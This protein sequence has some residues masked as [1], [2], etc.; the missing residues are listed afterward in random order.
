MP[1]LKGGLYVDD[2]RLDRVP[3]ATSEHIDKYPLTLATLPDK[4]TSMVLGVNWYT[5]FDSPVKRTVNGK[6]MYVI[7]DGDLGSVR[8][9][10]AICGRNWKVTDSQAWMLYYNQGQEGRCAE[11]SGL[12]VLSQLHRKRYD[13]T[14]RWHY[15]T[16]QE[17]DEWPGCFLGHNGPVYEGTSVRA[18][19]EVFRSKGAIPSQGK[20]SLTLDTAPPLVKQS[21]GIAAYR[22]ATSWANVRAALNVPD[23]LPGVP[24]NNSWGLGYPKEVILLDAAGERLLKEDGEM[25]IVTSS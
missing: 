10:H 16:A 5:N 17:S 8:G 21:E 3:S 20:K 7:G 1:Q 11:F 15:H 18:M 24:L 19:L 13:L 23:S 9:G 25:G 14:S 2:P 6:A 4:P 22:W 12:R